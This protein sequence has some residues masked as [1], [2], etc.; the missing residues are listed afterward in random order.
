MKKKL[1]PKFKINDRLNVFGP[2][3]CG[4]IDCPNVAEGGYGRCKYHLRNE[5]KSSYIP[6]SEGDF[7]PDGSDDQPYE[8]EGEQ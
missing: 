2:K 1:Q 7:M 5:S 8:P 3:Y 6:D 4:Y